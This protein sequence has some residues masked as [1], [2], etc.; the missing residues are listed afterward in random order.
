MII[1]VKSIDYNETS[2]IYHT[3]LSVDL[4]VIISP[5]E[6]EKKDLLMMSLF[7]PPNEKKIICKTNYNVVAFYEDLN[8]ILEKKTANNALYYDRIYHTGDIIAIG[9]ILN[10]NKNKKTDNIRQFALF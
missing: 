3:D 7:L 2:I 10:A 6:I 8:I 4:P 1:K 5:H 9:M